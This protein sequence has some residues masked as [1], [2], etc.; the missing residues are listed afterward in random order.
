MTP[1]TPLPH[2]SAKAFHAFTIY[3]AQG[4]KRSRAKVGR[5]LGVSRQN[6]DKWADRF[7]WSERV[8]A[9]MIEDTERTAKAAEQAALNIAEERERERLRFRQRALEVSRKATERALAILKQPLKGSRPHDA[10]RLL[11][12]GDAIG[13][14][15][16]GLNGASGESGAFGLH[17]VGMPNIKVVIHEDEQ[18]RQQR[19]RENEFFAAHPEIKRPANIRKVLNATIIDEN[20]VA[21]RANDDG[22]RSTPETD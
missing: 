20:G 12:V 6:I 21:R 17:P 8:R 14:A 2:E 4:P 16:L 15:A 9:A 13:R 3:L 7:H 19:K 22:L 11:A 18:S 10:A 1:L 5:E